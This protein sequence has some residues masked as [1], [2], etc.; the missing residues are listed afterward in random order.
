MFTTTEV[1]KKGACGNIF[2]A[3]KLPILNGWQRLWVLLTSIY[4]ALVIFA[5]ICILPI[6][7]DKSTIDSKISSLA[8]KK[9]L[10]YEY[11]VAINN[12]NDREILYS[13]RNLNKEVEHYKSDEFDSSLSDANIYKTIKKRYSGKIDFSA[14][15]KKYNRDVI[16]LRWLQVKFIF[17][18]FLWWS[19][20]C[21]ALYLLGIGVGWVLRGFKH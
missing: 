16:E 20:P 5:S 8:I 19:L 18:A 13:L 12:N 15:D 4:L 11:N 1:I 21:I 2:M 10:E 6:S 17:G 3:K 14:L 7:L 9:S